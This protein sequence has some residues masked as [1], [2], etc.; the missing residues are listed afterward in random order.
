MNETNE[1]YEIKIIMS[2]DVI[3]STIWI[4][5]VELR[6]MET[7]IDEDTFPRFAN[8]FLVFKNNS[9]SETMKKEE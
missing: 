4:D 5:G 7:Y 3:N 9:L 8:K 2:E 6:W 1:K